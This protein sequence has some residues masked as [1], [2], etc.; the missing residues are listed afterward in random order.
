MGPEMMVGDSL[1]VVNALRARGRMAIRRVFTTVETLAPRDPFSLTVQT[2][3]C[4]PEPKDAEGAC[5]TSI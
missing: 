5:A 3:D 4:G 1:A 2:V